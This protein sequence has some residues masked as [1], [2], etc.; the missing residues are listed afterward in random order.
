MRRSF[1]LLSATAI[2]L[3]SCSKKPITVSPLESGSILAPS[4]FVYALPRTLLNVDVQAVQRQ[5]VAGPYAPYAQKYLGIT[6]APQ[7]NTNVWHVERIVVS[8]TVESDPQMY[9][10]VEN[11]NV[12]MPDFERLM[13]SKLVLFPFDD[14]NKEVSSEIALPKAGANYFADMSVEPFIVEEKATYYSNV[15]KDSGFVRVPV[16]K[17]II[18]EKSL[19]DKARQAA[20]FI[21]SLRKKRVEF[22]TV[23]F[24]HT[25][26]GVGLKAALA[27]IDRLEKAY[28]EL[29]LGK[30]FVRVHHSSFEY[31]PTGEEESAILFRFSQQKGVVA[32][33]DLSGSPFMIEVKPQS[34]S[35]SLELPLGEG[36]KGDVE[37]Q[38]LFYRIPNYVWVKIGDGRNEMFTGRFKVFQANKPVRFLPKGAS[39]K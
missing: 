24:D 1:L 3:V 10:V 23:D 9:F 27:E 36:K 4:G 13:A 39:K 19:E 7:Q 31:V 16:H 25:L 30:E 8:S 14:S 38:Y 6:S 34:P 18:V 12:A 11:S 28:L 29:F 21:F 35:I 22:L 32:A 5:V 26:D 2:L 17:E 37:S 20:D 15:A 33:S